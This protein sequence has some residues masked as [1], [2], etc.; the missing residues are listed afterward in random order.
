MK[1]EKVDEDKNDDDDDDTRVDDDE[2]NKGN[3]QHNYVLHCPILNSTVMYCTQLYWAV[4]H[5]T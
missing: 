1:A 2:N 4:L 3:H 5:S